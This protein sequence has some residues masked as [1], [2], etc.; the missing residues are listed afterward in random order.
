MLTIDDSEN[1]SMKVFDALKYT[2][3]NTYGLSLSK[4]MKVIKQLFQK[5]ENHNIHKFHNYYKRQISHWWI[6]N[7]KESQFHFHIH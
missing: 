5:C 6:T 2:K 7:I 4:K 3:T 1:T